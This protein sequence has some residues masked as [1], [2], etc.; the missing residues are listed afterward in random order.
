MKETWVV[1]HAWVMGKR[2]QAKGGQCRG[3]ED[4]ETQ[5]DC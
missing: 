5:K 2:E 3:V 1:G 4:E